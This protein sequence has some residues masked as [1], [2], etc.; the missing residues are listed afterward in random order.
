MRVQHFDPLVVTRSMIQ[1]NL[2]Q[3]I[4]LSLRKGVI[5]EAMVVWDMLGGGDLFDQFTDR[6]CG[7]RDGLVR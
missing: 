2:F 3:T 1:R 5:G 7:L 6:G 4:K